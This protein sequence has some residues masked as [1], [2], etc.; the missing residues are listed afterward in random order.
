MQAAEGC[1]DGQKK[2]IIIYNLLGGW[3]TLQDMYYE[4]Y[5]GDTNSIH[6]MIERGF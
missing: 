1:A 2:N 4:L 5:H 3:Y 6:K